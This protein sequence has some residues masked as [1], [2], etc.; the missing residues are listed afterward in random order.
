MKKYFITATGTDIGKTYVTRLLARQF[1]AQGKQVRAIKPVAS[2]FLAEDDSSDTARLLEAC[3]LPRN[4]ETM[5]SVSP[6]RFAAPLSPDMAAQ[7]EGRELALSDLIAFCHSCAQESA[8]IVLA[9]GVGGVMV[10]LNSRGE[11]VL[12]WMVQLNWSVLLVS[13]T[14]LGTL[15]HTL[16]A[17]AAMRGRGIVPAAVIVS[18]SHGSPV[19][20]DETVQSLKRFIPGGVALV[21]LPRLELPEKMWHNVPD[22]TTL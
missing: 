8:D 6:W 1:R 21:A 13:G 20:L 7:R 2:G 11:T 3:G 9:E 10:P 19:T 14:Y 17:L 5:D 18:Q 16:T 12:D 22:L 4:A 15:S